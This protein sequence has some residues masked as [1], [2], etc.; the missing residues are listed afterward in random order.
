MD[1]QQVITF[2][3]HM[4]L[5]LLLALGLH[6]STALA[7]EPPHVDWHDLAPSTAPY[8]DPFLEMSYQQKDD[9]RTILDAARRVDDAELSQRAQEARVRLRDQGY[10]ADELLTQRLVVM[11]KRREEA[12]GVT[13]QYLGHEVSLDGYVLPLRGDNGRVF[14]FLLVPWVGACIHTPPPP[15]NQMV[16]VDVPEGIEIDEAFHAIRLRG[17]LEHEPSVSNLFLVD[18]Q[19]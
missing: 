16:R 7:N 15:P 9:L 11:E 12:T 19:R 14:S 1:A 10:D 4:V 18:G 5:L 3:G 2:F 6:P 8:D 13:G 17:I